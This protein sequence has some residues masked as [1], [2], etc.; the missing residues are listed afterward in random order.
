VT[1]VCVKNFFLGCPS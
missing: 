1:F